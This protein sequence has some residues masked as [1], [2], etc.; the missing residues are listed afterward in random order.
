MAVHASGEGEANIESTR[1]RDFVRAEEFVSYAQNLEDALLWRA[2]GRFGPGFYI[3]V[4]AGEPDA[5]SVTRAFYDRGWRGIN[6]EPMAG[7]Y[8]RLRNARIRDINLNVALEDEATPAKTY[9]SVDLDNGLSTGVASLAEQYRASGRD[10]AEVKVEVMTLANLF[11]TF[12][13]GEVHFLKIDVEGN[14]G[15]VFAG[16]DFAQHRPWVVLAECEVSTRDAD[17]LA[18]HAMLVANNYQFVY[19]DGL[20]R[21]YVAGEKREL[22]GPAFTTPVNWLD[23]VV[24]ARERDAEAR[25]LAEREELIA[26]VDAQSLQLAQLRAEADAKLAAKS[27]EL[28]ACHQELFEDSRHIA[29]LTAR[30]VNAE[31]AAADAAAAASDVKQALDAAQAETDR[32][33]ADLEE[34][35]GVL[36]V[37]EPKALGL[38]AE[39][40]DLKASTSWRLTAPVRRISASLRRKEHVR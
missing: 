17:E 6:V 35:R 28:D 11:D 26:R 24:H 15:L 9:F 21:Y 13:D 36:G 33:R 38:E 19:Y 2:L 20:N 37:Y 5:D 34:V 8:E 14:E 1:N 23:N 12:V 32:V 30:R 7:P 31:L 3:D 29:W 18:W 25:Y 27:R 40:R 22:L 39:I 4:G 10:V 16:G